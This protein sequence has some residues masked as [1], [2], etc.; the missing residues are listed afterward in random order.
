MLGAY[1]P[2]EPGPN[3]DDRR[4]SSLRSSPSTSRRSSTLRGKSSKHASNTSLKN[5]RTQSLSDGQSPTSFPSLLPPVSSSTN[6]YAQLKVKRSFADSSHSH[7]SSATPLAFNGLFTALNSVDQRGT[8]FDDAQKGIREVPGTLHLQNDEH[9]QRLVA[10]TGVVALIKQLAADLAQRDV[11]VTHLQR[12]AEERESLLKKMLR[13]CEV[14]NLDIEKRLRDLDSKKGLLQERDVRGKESRQNSVDEEYGALADDSI[15]GRM[16]L[17]LIDSLMSESTIPLNLDG[18][19][20]HSRSS[21]R[22]QDTSR[23]SSLNSLPANPGERRDRQV[24]GTP[25]KGW[26]DFFMGNANTVR[27]TSNMPSVSGDTGASKHRASFAGTGHPARQGSAL[28]NNLN[29]DSFDAPM[30]RTTSNS[31]SFRDLVSP[32]LS[33]RNAD[34]ASITSVSSLASWAMKLVGGNNTQQPGEIGQPVVHR[35]RA[36]TVGVTSTRNDFTKRGT[37]TRAKSRA[38]TTQAATKGGRLV[39]AV[40]TPPTTGFGPSGTIKKAPHDAMR[41]P[42]STMMLAASPPSGLMSSSNLGPVEMD[43]ILPEDTRPPTLLPYTNRGSSD[44]LTDRF[45]FIYDQRRRRR[46]NE[47][48]ADARK[49]KNDVHVETFENHRRAHGGASEDEEIVDSSE[50]VSPMQSTSRPDTPMGKDFGDADQ[51]QRR[52]QDYLKISS[53]PTELLSHTPSAAPITSVTTADGIAEESDKS[54]VVSKRGSAPSSNRVEASPSRVVSNHAELVRPAMPHHGSSDILAKSQL[55]PVKSLLDQLTEVHDN[56]QR[57]K[58]V[59]WNDFLRK[60]R[61]ERNRNKD[62]V[63]GLENRPKGFTM[64][65]TAMTDGEVIGIAG[66]GNKGKVGRAKWSEFRTLVLGGIPVT[67]RAK[68][69]AECCGATGL[70]IPG[71]YEDLT[72]SADSDPTIVQQIQMDI[73]RTLTDNIFF[74]KGPGVEKLKEVLLAYARRNPEIGYCQGMNMIAANLLLILPTAEDAFWVLTSMIENILPEKYYD[75][76]L[77]A[78][79][80]DQVVLRQY[81]TDLLPQLSDHL[82][83]LSIEL[84]ALT[85]Q[86]F[87]SVFTDCLS[88]EAL[89]RVWDVVLCINDG[90][91]FLFQ[92]ALAL[93][94]LNEQALL[95]C[96]SPAEIYGYINQQ[97]TDHAISIDGLIRASEALKK[98]IK[99]EEVAERRHAAIDGELDLNRQ[100]EAIRKGKRRADDTNKPEV[101]SSPAREPTSARVESPSLSRKSSYARA[102]ED[103]F[104]EYA[105]LQI[106]TPMPID[107][108][109]DWRG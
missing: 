72:K 63:V 82:E 54:V 108:E 28:R 109:I 96:E 5:T 89:F 38:D 78:S 83:A 41:N 29:S 10:R 49:Q 48:A 6:A 53:Y 62:T 52:W 64:P 81:V 91:S 61:A 30:H 35:D 60:V 99:R 47:A 90:A 14:S 102:L 85:F 9:I 36:A 86:W 39:D 46:Q 55:D 59:K 67:Y 66:L 107:E 87:L 93:L 51:R 4:T 57:E 44:L 34:D 94:K 104:D 19:A 2:A 31:S 8:L 32:E 1:D 95:S 22:S 106:R 12:R 58:T 74:R 45:G 17:A 71:Y 73:T 105:E 13:E 21:L 15:D 18:H 77:L 76:S 100:R 88:A 70:R 27:K 33:T 103:Q 25:S 50:P 24:S 92:V 37:L 7:V 42:L 11:E 98:V 84:E 40:L 26:K 23:R 20:A 79:R 80:A 68:I 97:M 3:G 75:S 43:T 56:L 69:W 16:S 65:E 101:A